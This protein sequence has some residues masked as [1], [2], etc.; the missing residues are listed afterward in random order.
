MSKFSRRANEF[1]K[2]RHGAAP[3]DLG[4]TQQE[5]NL[6]YSDKLDEIYSEDGS[7]IGLSCVVGGAGFFGSAFTMTALVDIFGV[8]ATGLPL[9]TILETTVAGIFTVKAA[10]LTTAAGLGYA[11]AE[12]ASDVLGH[13][14]ACNSP[15]SDVDYVSLRTRHRHGYLLSR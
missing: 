13:H 2:R 14:A 11:A 10:L 8:A 1:F 6:I 3:R 5:V 4:L 9:A 12:K 15:L 7:V